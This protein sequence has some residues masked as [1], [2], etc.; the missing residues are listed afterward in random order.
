MLIRFQVRRR[1]P[2]RLN[3]GRLGFCNEI[4]SSESDVGVKSGPS[5][6]LPAAENNESKQ[7]I[8]KGVKGQ[9]SKGLVV[10]VALIH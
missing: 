9:E 1:L 2:L 4:F 7:A 10:S 3:R 8:V 5:E 6:G